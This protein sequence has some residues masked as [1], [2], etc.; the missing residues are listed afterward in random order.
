MYHNLFE[1]GSG[2][3]CIKN[4]INGKMYIGSAVDLKNRERQHFSALRLNKH[5]SQYLQNSFNKHGKENFIFEVIEFVEEKENLEKREEYYINLYDATNRDKGYNRRKIV[6]TNLG[7]RHSEEARAKISEAGKNRPSKNKGVPLPQ[8]V[9]DKIS[10][11]LMGNIPW[12]K[13]IPM[14]EETKEKLSEIYKNS[15]KKYGRDSGFVPSDESKLKMSIAHLGKVATE[16]TRKKMSER[17]RGSNNANYGHLIPTE[18]N[19]HLGTKRP[20]AS[21]SYI[22]V[23]IR[24]NNGRWGSN[25]SFDKHRIHIGV[26]STEEEAALAYNKKAIELYGDNARLNIIQ[27]KE[28]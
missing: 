19:K 20:N 5:R 24:R 28:A 3:Y 10:K 23:S 11:S 13:G 15:E 25:I 7:L 2:I 4:I 9:K 17:H 14:K 22:G 18:E 21:S 8:D 12:N 27:E 16:E 6:S 26:F 1:N